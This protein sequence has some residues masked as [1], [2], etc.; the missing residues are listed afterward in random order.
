MAERFAEL[1][2]RW[3]E[4]PVPADDLA[5][6]R[7]IRDRAPSGMEIAAGEYGYDL[8][9]FRE[10]LAAGAVDCLQAD[11]TRCAGLS[12]FLA[13]GTLAHSFGL[14]LSAHCAPAFH[15]HAACSLPNFRHLEYFH[16]H[17]RIEKMF[18]DGHVSPV[19]GEMHPDLSRPGLGLELKQVD[20]E[21]L[22][23]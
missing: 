2:V 19:N 3:F 12:G 13:A 10:M 4:E 16:D 22:R 20:V 7:L 21:Q 23:I 8:N 1:D 5:G 11:G 6:L 15:L 14:Q 9:Y 17:S 18:F